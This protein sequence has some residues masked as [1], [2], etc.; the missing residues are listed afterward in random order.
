MKNCFEV[1]S[2]HVFFKNER[3]KKSNEYEK[4]QVKEKLEC[5][6]IC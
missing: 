1:V 3:P 6:K 5:C 4:H 2:I